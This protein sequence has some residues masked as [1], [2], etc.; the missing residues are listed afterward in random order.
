ML[1]GSVKGGQIL[2]TYPDEFTENGPRALSRGRMLP[3]TPWDA[4]WNGVAEWFGVPASEMD[5]VMPHRQNFMP[6]NLLFGK[7]DLFKP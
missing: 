5:K 1:G 4:M 7:D 2:G 3:T 6:E